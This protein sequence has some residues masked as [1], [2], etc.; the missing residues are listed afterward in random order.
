MASLKGMKAVIT[1]GGLG[2]RLLPFSKEIPKEMSP[3]LMKS[4][5]N[6]ILVKPI[7]QAIFEQL[8]D[9]GIR[10]FLAVVGRGKRA[11]E[12]HFTPDQAF[13][14]FLKQK[15]KSAASLE[16]FYEKIASSNLVFIIQSEPRGF[17]DAVLRTRGYISG[18][19]IV[20]AGDTYLISPNS[21]YLGRLFKAH[22][23]FDAEA[24]ILLQG[25][26]DPWN[27]GIVTGRDY[28]AGILAIERA[29]EKPADFISNTAIMPVYI[30]K[31]SIFRALENLP[32]GRGGELQL[33][34]AIQRLISEG[35]KVVGVKLSDKEFR[36]DIGSPQTLMDALAIS[37]QHLGRDGNNSL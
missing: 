3:I 19:F 1:A 37:S 9:Y 16:D 17:G 32:A 36:L 23:E 12:D 30:F 33:T 10:D 8:Y 28:S 27:Y 2:T 26:K 29:V 34:D 15:G 21:E 18:E 7:I 31:E 35:K 11:I 5:D 14:A 24:T 20:H 22:K 13:V 25:V 6:T 4:S